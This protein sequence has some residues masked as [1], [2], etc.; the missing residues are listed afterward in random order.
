MSLL[1]ERY[2][3]LLEAETRNQGAVCGNP[4]VQFWSS[5]TG[6]CI[7]DGQELG[8]EYFT[9]NLISQARFNTAVQRLIQAQPD[10]FF[11]EI[12]PHSTLADPLR[13]ICSAKG[14]DYNYVPTMQ[15]GEDCVKSALTAVG[16]LYQNGITLNYETLYPGG[17]VLSNLPQYAWK[18]NGAYWYESRLSKEWRLRKVSHHKLL[19][20]RVP[21]STTFEPIWRNMLSLGD[22]PW[23]MDHKIVNDVVFPFAGY[24]TMAGA[25]VRQI[26]GVD[27]GYRIRCAIA[28]TALVLWEST[29]VEII[30]TLRQHKSSDLSHSMWFEFTISSFSGSTWIRNCQGQ[31]RPYAQA[32]PHQSAPKAEL[33]RQINVS[34]WY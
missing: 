28:H 32:L 14:V 26:T 8:S 31:V 24:L 21:E 18:R 27:G 17:R 16:Q 6:G 4:V 12:G 9:T 13:Q 34:G 7:R 3:T 22:G 20:L 30:T 2:K 5:V 29:P 1:T 10:N 19:G 23:L 33:S 25:A 11:I 15:R